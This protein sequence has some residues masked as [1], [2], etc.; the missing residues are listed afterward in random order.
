MPEATT[1]F[2]GLTEEEKKSLLARLDRRS[3][4][5]RATVIAEGDQLREM[6]VI[7][8]GDAE[9]HLA[10]RLGTERVVNRVGP[11]STLGEI[12]LLSGIPASATVTATTDL[13]LLVVDRTDL[14][15][16]A[17][18]FPRIHLNLAAILSQR[19]AVVTRRWIRPPVGRLTFLIDAGAPPMLGYALACSV[20]W[21]TRESTVWALLS[22]E[23]GAP[24]QLLPNLVNGGGRCA[25]P[26]GATRRL[27]RDVGSLED[28]RQNFAHVLVQVAPD[29]TLPQG[30]RIV[31]L[32]AGAEGEGLAAV[33]PLQDAA[34]REMQG[35]TL[36]AVT[37]TGRAL[38]RVAR[39][40]SGLTVGLALGSGTARG[41][42]HV[43]VLRALARVGLEPDCVAGTSI[44][45]A[46]AGLC[47]LG[48][49]VDG[50]AD[51]L[52]KVG[53]QAFRLTLPGRSVLSVSGVREGLRGICGERRIEDLGLPVAIVA[54]DLLS[55]REIV[56][57][58]GLL[59][60][61]VLSSLSI[62][63]I[64]PAQRMNDYL[65][66]DGGIIAP[67]PT[68]AAARLG[69]GVVL[70]VKLGRRSWP[71]VTEAEA[72]EPKGVGPSV[73]QSALGCLELMRSKMSADAA[74]GAT[75]QIEPVFPP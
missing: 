54:A 55:G 62:P 44:G 29:A 18:D 27:L 31:H 69:A 67:V 16:L 13:E 33:P 58:R 21:H 47:G 12:S 57:R 68:A 63:G 25:D 38:G 53:A 4:P 11:G 50:I 46:V 8:A 14:P 23:H 7:V 49:P 28:L 15:S 9:V 34:L 72:A 39:M 60:S 75:I 61:A 40:L 10:D 42:A 48:Y 6:Y 74:A 52:D 36:S 5:A 1:F 45:A 17:A 19:L 64:Y 41:Y 59:W 37:P 24:E 73:L 35:G 70:G 2:T 71:P 65:L 3:F 51:A 56:F 22:P 43:G 32:C 30:E 26:R 66:V 20:A